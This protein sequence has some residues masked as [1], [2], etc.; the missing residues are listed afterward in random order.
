[1]FG[2]SFVGAIDLDEHKAG[3]IISLL[4]DVEASHARF[5]HALPRVLQGGLL[6]RFNRFGSYVN[7]DVNDKHAFQM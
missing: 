3:R 6:K 5:F 2:G 4:E 1:M 7:M